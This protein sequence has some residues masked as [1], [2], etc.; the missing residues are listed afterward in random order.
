MQPWLI[1]VRFSLHFLFQLCLLHGKQESLKQWLLL[2][3]HMFCIVV[4]LNLGLVLVN[5]ITEY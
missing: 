1:I 5:Y 2:P 4:Y 3:L